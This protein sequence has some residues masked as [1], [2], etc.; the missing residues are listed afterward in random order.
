MIDFQSQIALSP[1]SV[2]STHQG[3]R[4]ARLAGLT[5]AETP[6]AIGIDQ[7]CDGGRGVRMTSDVR[8][9][10]SPFAGRVSGRRAGAQHD[11]GGPGRVPTPWVV[12]AVVRSTPTQNR[13]PES[14]SS[15]MGWDLI[16][17]AMPASQGDDPRHGCGH[18]FFV[19]S[20]EAG[21]VASA[22]HQLPIRHGHGVQRPNHRPASGSITDSLP[23]TATVLEAREWWRAVTIANIPGKIGSRL[24]PYAK[25]QLIKSA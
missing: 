23:Q 13:P 18:L 17:G 25:G 3:T 24:G 1:F 5:P 20:R 6:S 8:R 9:P 16:D 15:S 4:W 2:R 21:A 19:R 12:Q 14:A 22:D 11:F 10:E 7:D